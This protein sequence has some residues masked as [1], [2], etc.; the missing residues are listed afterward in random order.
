MGSSQNPPTSTTQPPVSARPSVCSASNGAWPM[1]SAPRTTAVLRSRRSPP[2]ELRLPRYGWH[3]C[4]RGG[5]SLNQESKP[6]LLPTTNLFRLADRAPAAPAWAIPEA[7]NIRLLAHTSNG[8]ASNSRLANHGYW[9][10]VKIL[11]VWRNARSSFLHGC[12]GIIRPTKT[13]ERFW[14]RLGLSRATC[15]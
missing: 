9:S 7:A 11:L 1:Q 12:P 6:P 10:S 4:R 2:D 15:I 13:F 3:H 14:R 5:D 8:E